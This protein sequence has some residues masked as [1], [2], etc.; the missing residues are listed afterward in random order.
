MWKNPN[1][2]R[3]RNYDTFLYK[4]VEITDLKKKDIPIL[5]GKKKS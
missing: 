3:Q 5:S 1:V 4:T 2:K